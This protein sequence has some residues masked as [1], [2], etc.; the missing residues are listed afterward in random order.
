MIKARIAVFIL[1]FC[2]PLIMPTAQLA[3]GQDIAVEV[4]QRFDS[5]E[6]FLN[7][8]IVNQWVGLNAN[9]SITGKLVAYDEAGELLPRSGVEV[10]LVQNGKAVSRGLTDTAG[11]FQFKE[12][13]VG[14]YNFVA[15]S[16]YSFATFGIHVLAVG[17]GSPTSFEVCVSTASSAS[18]KELIKENW[19]PAESEAPRVYEKDPQ[20]G[21][22]IVST[23]P[24]V[25]LQNGDLLGQ[26]S[27]PGL[28]ISEQDLTGNVA[29]ILKAGRSVAA[30]PIGRDGKFRIV[31]L[32]PGIY[33][34]VVVGKNGNAVIGFEAVGPKPIANH[35]SAAAGR[36]VSFQE[37][38]N[39]LNIELA[40]PG[41][42]TE[43]VPSPTFEETGMMDPGYG[44]PFIGGGFASPGGFN[45]FSGGSG[46][47]GGGIGGGGGGF[48]GGGLGGLL[49]IA[50]L[51]VGVAAISGNDNFNPDQASIIAP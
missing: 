42:D 44:Q 17:S 50:G 49:G 28:Q 27:R 2:G 36:L 35:R 3:F 16:E 9:K 19:I 33:D 8:L 48:G 21:K 30:A 26:V 10:S 51:A 38:A 7:P 22:R 11:A 39:A 15:Q 14:T 25:L 41:L 5:S 43:E 24:K 20:V 34:L 1:G 6:V 31:S 45:G 12:I 37:T 32:A 47:G 18:A 46:S 29:H 13:S 40:T 4:T 23:S